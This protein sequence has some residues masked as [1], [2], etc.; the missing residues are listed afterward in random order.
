MKKF[1]YSLFAAAT[2][3]FATTSCTED[4]I[5]SQDGNEVNVSFTVQTNGT[6]GS[7]AIADGVDVGKG[8][9]AN[10]LVYA[11]YEDGNS[12]DVLIQNTVE[13]TEEGKFTVT[14]PLA[15]NITYDIVFFAYNEEGNAFGITKENA[16]TINLQ[17]LKLNEKLL[18][19]E[20]AYDAFFKTVN[21]YSPSA[22][23]TT[24]TLNRPFAQLNAGT[25]L[26]DLADAAD[27]DVVVTNSKIVVKKAHNQFNAFTGEATGE[28]EL[29]YTSTPVLKTTSEAVKQESQNG[30]SFE[31]KNET[32]NVKGEKETFY[33]LSLA[34]VLACDEKELYDV[35]VTFYRNTDDEVN[36]LSIPNLNLQRNYRTNIIGNLL[37][38]KET[39][40]VV[41]D[42]IFAEKEYNYTAW[43]GGVKEVA[44]V[45]G[46][47]N[48]A[49]AEELA[50]IAQEV[51][52]GNNSFEGKTVKLI[53]NIDLKNIA[54]TTIG[55]NGDAAGFKGTFEGEGH[56][57]SN[58]YIDQTATPAYQA[59]GL[60]GSVRGTLNNFTVKNAVIKNLSTG[61]ATVNGT[62]VIAGCTGYGATITN[63]TVE[64]AEVYANRMVGGIAGYAAGEVS[65]CTVKNIK[66]VATPDD[67]DKDGAYDN[68]DKVGGIIGTSNTPQTLLTNNTV[69]NI[70]IIGY[71]D[72]GGIAGAAHKAAEAVKNNQVKEGSVVA[73]MVSYNCGKTKNDANVGTIIGRILSNTGDTVDASNVATNVTT[74]IITGTASEP[75]YDDN[76][77]TYIVK[78][79][80]EWM[81]FSGKSLS[82]VT[83]SIEADINYGGQEFGTLCASG[84]KDG[85][86]NN[87]LIIKG[88]GHT[89]KNLVVVTGGDYSGNSTNSHSLFHTWDW[90][91]PAGHFDSKLIIS[92]LTLEGI[93]VDAPEGYAG[94]I[95]AYNQGELILNNVDVKNSTI[96]GK[97]SIGAIIG[98]AEQ[99]GSVIMRDCDVIACNVTASEE[100][101]AGYLGR[102]TSKVEITNCTVDDATQIKAQ[103]KAN[104]Y[105]GERYKTCPSLTIDG[106]EYFDAASQEKLTEYLASDVTGEMKIFLGTDV[107]T[108]VQPR[109]VLWGGTSTSSVTINGNGNELKL[110]KGDSDWNAINLGNTNG[111]LVL[112]DLVWSA[113]D[114]GNGA[115]NNYSVTIN[116]EVEM[117]NVKAT[118]A[119]GLQQ[120]STLKNV[121][122][123]EQGD[124]YAIYA[125][126]MGQT[127]T[128]D[129]LTVTATNG[130]RGI[131]VIDQYTKENS[132]KVTLNVS[133]AKFETA[134]KAAILVTSIAGADINLSN[135]DITNVKADK[136]NAVWV[137]EERVQYAN[138]VT[139]TGGTKKLEGITA[140]T[141]LTA[142]TEGVYEINSASDLAILNEMMLKQDKNILGKNAKI[143]LTNDVDFT[144]YVWTPVDSHAD[145]AFTLAEIDGNSKTISNLTVNGQAMFTRFAGSG[146]VTIKNLTFDN[147]TVTSN[148]LN[149]SILTVQSYQNVTLDNVDVKNSTITG[150]YKV[151]PLIATVYDENENV[152]KTLTLKD[153]DVENTIVKGSLDFMV[154]GMVAWVAT[155]NK[156]TITFENCTV[157][158]VTLQVPTNGQYS[159]YGYVYSTN[160]KAEDTYNEAKGV[161]VTNC[162]VEKY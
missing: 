56:I 43:A 138:L 18:A 90:T 52:A 76:T 30:A 146:D 117:N 45:D 15:K 39:F 49:L 151:A 86:V 33:Y 106:A 136:I 74:D 61:S 100:R 27:L 105:V 141:K 124:Y 125:P 92:D 46:V 82:N 32:F 50:W 48:I 119:I 140:D 87:G 11:V 5:V 99:A 147:A 71:R 154:C 7:R 81:W 109:S 16:R 126:A 42:P 2:M 41:I 65:N 28:T 79:A 53:S 64:D 55:L 54:W 120:N 143:K 66:L 101:A 75:T 142:N 102:A 89:I 115:W 160:G 88:N 77:K 134:K 112:N 133:N 118:R 35:D 108:T 107:E 158:N 37:T 91:D 40:K 23:N 155:S 60:F 6:T 21:D 62:A 80:D 116:C 162:K 13:E 148:T 59:A 36:T 31:F 38:S 95:V 94:V 145:R 98:F 114:N 25:T 22:G 29:D 20:E 58:L 68:G 57:I 130:G 128:I 97:K 10:T 72:L 3:L 83:I 73:D 127:I 135:V 70:T 123:N 103:K 4:E 161:T 157:N 96:N 44:E 19:N 159:A 152:G 85:E 17:E 84:I 131:K 51:N 156:E 110:I 122:I 137:D 1:F 144:E 121:T 139:V 113:D 150:N 78:T 63:V 93:K 69:E 24:V 26:Q 111:K 9:M 132:K 47:Y 149:T 129:G 104:K 8:N 12:S 67:L 153:C 34:Y 14:I